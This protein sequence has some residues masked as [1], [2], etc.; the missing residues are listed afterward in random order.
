MP[1]QERTSF[2]LEFDPETLEL[3]LLRPMDRKGKV[4]RLPDDPPSRTGTLVTVIK[5]RDEASLLRDRDFKSL[6]LVLKA[7]QKALRRVF[8]V[9]IEALPESHERRAL[10]LSRTTWGPRLTLKEAAG[11]V[12]C[13]YGDVSYVLST[14]FMEVTRREDEFQV[15]ARLGQPER[16]PT[17]LNNGRRRPNKLHRSVVAR[18]L[19]RKP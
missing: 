15:P 1:W 13:R 2:W 12:G 11:E 7:E 10:Q 3:V 17:S 14:V 19:G 18:L 16:F 4:L 5:A 8:D 6:A 9:V